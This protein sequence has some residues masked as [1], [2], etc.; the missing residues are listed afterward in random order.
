[1]L[2]E[3]KWKKKFLDGKI[4]SENNPILHHPNAFYYKIFFIKYICN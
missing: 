4:A 3:K 1:M 2:L